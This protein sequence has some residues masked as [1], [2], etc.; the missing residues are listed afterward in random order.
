M[1]IVLRL[2]K[3]FEDLTTVDILVNYEAKSVSLSF[4]CGA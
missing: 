2:V 4:L 1:Y 3:R